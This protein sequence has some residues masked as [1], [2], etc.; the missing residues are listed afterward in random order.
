MSSI[1]GL[2]QEFAKL[3]D[4]GVLAVLLG[5]T[6]LGVII[7]ALPGLSATMGIALLTGLTYKFPVVYTFAIL[8]G[9]YVGAIYGGSMSAILLNIPGTAS[10]AATALEGYPLAK[11][12]KAETAIKVTRGASILGTFIGVLALALVAPPLSKV[13]L[14]FTSPE[15]FMLEIG[16]AHV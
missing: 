13:A 10:A 3:M 12:G 2:F 14:M 11:Q 1:I 15:Y 6:M 16:R 4:I 8:M 7:G 5:A 9:V